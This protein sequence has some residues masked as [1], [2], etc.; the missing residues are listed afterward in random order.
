M[1]TTADNVL[2]LNADSSSLPIIITPPLLPITGPEAA[3]PAMI[4]PEFLLVDG[5]GLDSSPLGNGPGELIELA[6]IPDPVG[7]SLGLRPAKD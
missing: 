7:I 1:P 2:A 4:Q 3:F 5:M 6:E